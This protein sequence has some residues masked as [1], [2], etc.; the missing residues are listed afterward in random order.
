MK[1]IIFLI[2]ILSVFGCTSFNDV[3][4]GLEGIHTITILGEDVRDTES[5]AYKQANAFAKIKRKRQSS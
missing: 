3:R 4:P 5:N 2:S 1:N